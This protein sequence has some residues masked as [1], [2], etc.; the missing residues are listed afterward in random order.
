MQITL[1]I[2]HR[3]LPRRV[4]SKSNV[5]LGVDQPRTHRCTIG[6]DHHIRVSDAALADYTDTIDT[7]IDHAD[8]ITVGEWLAPVTGNN[9]ADIDDGGSHLAGTP[10]VYYAVVLDFN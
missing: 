2:T 1:Q 10:C 8:R 6:I 5:D 9:R 4:V 3:F 7:T